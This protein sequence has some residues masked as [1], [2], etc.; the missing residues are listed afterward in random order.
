[1]Q[2]HLLGLGLGLALTGCY[3]SQ[4]LV[5][6]INAYNDGLEDETGSTTVMDSSTVPDEP[7]PTSSS[8]SSTTNAP[9]SSTTDEEGLDLPPPAFAVTLTAS[10]QEL[11]RAGSIVLTADFEGEPTWLE[12]R[13]VQDG[14]TLDVPTWPL[15]ES[16]LEY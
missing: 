5:D 13:V 10:T 12:L 1:M 11:K 9:P 6:N 4:A 16:T 15:D 8:T 14:M 3:D 7:T 2:V